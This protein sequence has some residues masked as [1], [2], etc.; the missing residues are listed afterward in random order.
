MA[1]KKWSKETK[2][3]QKVAKSGQRHL[4]KKGKK[5]QRWPK[6][7][8]RARLPASCRPALVFTG[9]PP[10]GNQRQYNVIASPGND[11][12]NSAPFLLTFFPFCMK[13]FFLTPLGK[14]SAQ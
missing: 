4:K 1:T 11:W 3:S 9:W 5:C 6:E 12:G 8:K 14:I 13:N 10:V 7:A 2:I